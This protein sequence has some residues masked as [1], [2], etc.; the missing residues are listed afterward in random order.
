[1]STSR[2]PWIAVRTDFGFEVYDESEQMVATVSQT[3]GC[4][5]HLADAYDRAE[6]IAAAPLMRDALRRIARM[7]ETGE[8]GI[9]EIAAGALAPLARPKAVKP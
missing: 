9:G 6:L 3:C 5:E 1:M 2:S 7:A 8:Y 4:A